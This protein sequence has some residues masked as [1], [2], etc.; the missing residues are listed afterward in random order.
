MKVNEISSKFH[1]YYHVHYNLLNLCDFRLASISD[2][3]GDWISTRISFVCD[4]EF[5]LQIISDL[6]LNYIEM[7]S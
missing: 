2:F 4:I 7:I 6:S 3:C 1:I 5:L